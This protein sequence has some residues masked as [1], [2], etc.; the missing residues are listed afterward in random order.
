[1]DGGYAQVL[2]RLGFV[3]SVLNCLASRLDIFTGAFHRITTAQC[4]QQRGGQK[5]T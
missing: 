4:R 3:G 1:M 2:L 5:C